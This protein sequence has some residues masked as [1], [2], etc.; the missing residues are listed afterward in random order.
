MKI[1]NLIITIFTIID[2]FCQKYFPMRQL[3]RR[4]L[5]PKFADSEVI[6]MEVVG[7]FIG[8]HEDKSIYN[9]F[10]EHWH[11]FSRRCRISAILSDKPRIFGKL[12]RCCLNICKRIRENGCRFLIA[13]LL[14]FVNSFGPNTL[15]CSKELRA[16]ANG[17]DKP[18]LV[19]GCI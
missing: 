1:L 6:T 18:S 8:F 9:Y 15:N 13:C 10:R 12:K 5:L 2:D 16:M 4:G 3:R 19:I 17:L 7:E 14:R 11:I